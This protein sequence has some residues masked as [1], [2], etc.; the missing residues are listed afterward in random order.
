MRLIP[1]AWLVL[2]T[3]VWAAQPV[4]IQDADREA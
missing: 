4:E 2:P 3:L 1:A